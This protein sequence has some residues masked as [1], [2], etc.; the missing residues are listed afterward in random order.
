[1]KNKATHVGIFSNPLLPNDCKICAWSEPI[2]IEM[3]TDTIP[4]LSDDDMKYFLED[5]IMVPDVKVALSMLKYTFRKY[6]LGKD[7]Y[8]VPARIAYSK[9]IVVLSE[10]FDNV[11]VLIQRQ[12][13]LSLE[14]EK[15]ADDLTKLE[16]EME[17]E[18]KAKKRK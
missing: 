3:P 1:M 14:A 17:A 4:D 11:D 16:K 9:A 10:F 6:S 18:E 2:I 7:L 15:E 5:S 8:M 12:I 13:E